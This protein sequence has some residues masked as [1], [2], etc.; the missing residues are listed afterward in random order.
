MEALDVHQSI[1]LLGLLYVIVFG[2]LMV[3]G[4]AKEG[5][6]GPWP[7]NPL[8]CVYLSTYRDREYINC[9]GFVH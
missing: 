5:R 9:R 4:G 2:R 6:A 7:P 1:F 3:R 8:V